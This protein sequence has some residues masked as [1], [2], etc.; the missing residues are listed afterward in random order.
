M[1]CTIIGKLYGI[2]NKNVI[3]VPDMYVIIGVVFD[4][5]NA[6]KQ[7]VTT[8]HKQHERSFKST[9]KR[10]YHWWQSSMTILI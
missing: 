4:F 7:P 9:Y 2:C 1:T 6:S 3:G 5:S 10:K 8:M